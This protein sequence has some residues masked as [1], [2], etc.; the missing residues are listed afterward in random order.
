MLIALGIVYVIAVLALELVILPLYVY[1][2]I[3]MLLE[4]DQASLEGDRA[5]EIIEERHILGDEVGQIMRSRNRALAELRRHEDELEQALRRLE[6]QDRLVSIG[7]LSAGVAH[8]L[9]T[10]LAVLQGSIEK[11]L[12][13]VSAPAAQERLKRMLRVTERLRRISESLLD[14][15]RLRTPEMEAV[16]LRPVVD[17]AWSLVEIDE[18]AGQARFVNRVEDGACVRGNPDRLIQVFVNLL[19]NSL[20]EIRPGGKIEVAAGRNAD[21]VTAT[22]ED[23]GPGIPDE[24][25]PA[26]FEAFVTSRLDARGTGLGLAVAEGIVR[27][28]GGAIAAANRPGGGAR[29]TMRLPAA[30]VIEEIHTD[31]TKP[32]N[33]A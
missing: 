22:V 15:A 6:E 31:E 8:E 9:N 2:P 33:A 23:D 19:R 32:R 12:E 5:R 18:R 11:L 25:L 10:P 16:A 26:I 21:W 30:P 13:T 28:H 17:E 3:K 7:M 24:V 4:A 14:F 29:I 1:R 20:H 27:Q